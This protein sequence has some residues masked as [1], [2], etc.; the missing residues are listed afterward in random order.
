MERLEAVK[1]KLGFGIPETVPS[2]A[3]FPNERKRMEEERRVRLE[4]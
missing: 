3:Y 1:G 4:K 2:M